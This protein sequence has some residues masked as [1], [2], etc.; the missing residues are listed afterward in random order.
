MPIA[1]EGP[2]V[3]GVGGQ[4]EY[5]SEGV[6]EDDGEMGEVVPLNGAR[7]GVR[8]IQD[9]DLDLTVQFTDAVIEEDDYGFK[10]F[11]LVVV[12]VVVVVV[13]GPFLL[14]LFVV[15]AVL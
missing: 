3:I 6:S 7:H 11:I 9:P 1:D 13:L 5:P 15:P 10:V 12:V 2:V 14:L 8:G 4:P